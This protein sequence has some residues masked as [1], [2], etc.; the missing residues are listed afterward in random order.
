MGR[1]TQLS[2]LDEEALANCVRKYLCLYDKT[3]PDYKSK[4]CVENAWRKVDEEMGYE[5]GKYTSFKL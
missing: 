3:S 4:N 1:K 2:L 5:E